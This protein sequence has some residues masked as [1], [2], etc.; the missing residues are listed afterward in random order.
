[1]NRT[2]DRVI[3]LAA[4]IVGT[5]W[6]LADQAREYV[7]SILAILANLASNLAT[8]LAS[9]IALAYTALKPLCVAQARA[10]ASLLR[11]G[12]TLLRV[13]SPL[14]LNRLYEALRACREQVKE[15]V[16][17]VNKNRVLVK[18]LVL[19]NLEN[20]LFSAVSRLDQK[21]TKL[22]SWSKAAWAFRKECLA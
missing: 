11:Q 7:P 5:A 15:L 12:G 3:D 20:A 17:L 10:G 16:N 13:Y 6:D 1:M 19:E 21:L 2:L 22:K 4:Y 8:C 9:C 18:D 14:L